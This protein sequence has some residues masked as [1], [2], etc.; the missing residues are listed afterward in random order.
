MLCCA[1]VCCAALWSA[2]LWSAALRCAVLWSAVLCCAA[3]LGYTTLVTTCP[4]HH[5]QLFP[6]WYS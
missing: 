5:L 6:T 3:A 1:V 4:R 2:V